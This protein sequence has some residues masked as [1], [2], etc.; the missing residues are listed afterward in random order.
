[1]VSHSRRRIVLGGAILPFAGLLGACANPPP[2]T[3]KVARNEV[4]APRAPPPMRYEAIP[5]M[6]PGGGDTLTWTPGYWRW[7]GTDF[8]WMAG[9]YVERPR[10]EAYWVPARWERRGTSWVYIEGHW[11]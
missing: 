9:T 10:R 2:P 8:A 1:M 4:L 11:A 5:P 3:D 7:D 6:P